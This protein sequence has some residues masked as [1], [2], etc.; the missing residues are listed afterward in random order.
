VVLHGNTVDA[1]GLP[2]GPATES[3][4]IDHLELLSTGRN[5]L[6]ALTLSAPLTATYLRSTTYVRANV[7]PA[8]HGETVR[9]D[10]LGSGN[11]QPWQDFVVKKAPVTYVQAAGGEQPVASTL[12]VSV[13]GVE[14][15]ETP[16]LSSAQPG[17]RLFSTSQDLTAHTTVHFGDTTARP[18]TGK[19]N[20]RA[21][22]RRGLGS[23][24]ALDADQITTL[25]DNLPGLKA[26]TNPEP[27]AGAA[28]AEQPA[29]IK[30]NAPASVRTFGRAV[31][32]QDY[33][34]LALSFP[35]ISMARADWVRHQ[36]GRSLPLPEIQLTVAGS[37]RAPVPAAYLSQLRLYLDLHRDVNVP[38]RL[39]SYTPVYLDA[40]AEVD[41]DDRYGRQAT[42]TAVVAA[43]N[44]QLNPDGS[45]GFFARLGFG[46]PVFLSAVYATVQTVPGVRA[47]RI[48]DL[49]RPTDPAGTVVERLVVKP[50]ELAVIANDPA[51]DA[52]VH[53]T[54]RVSLGP[55]GFPD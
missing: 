55:G 41:V 33:T 13:N 12:R 6:T 14:W 51:D 28:D 39:V 44:P 15:S 9:Q 19:D 48:T 29:Q 52:G 30:V 10:I 36:A 35:G 32:A 47:V 3:A 24:G 17:A 27:T 54:L 22:Y 23:Q 20:I 16:T 37:G 11:G 49:R 5:T 45:P 42:L 1:G 25:M 7:A 46:E 8:S 38:L 4:L 53:G 21:R 43:L 40:G 2:A 31:S 34:S 18:P 50:I 26:V